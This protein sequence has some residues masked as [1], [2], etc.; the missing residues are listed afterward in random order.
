MINR[1]LAGTCAL[2]L[3]GC[4]GKSGSYTPPKSDSSTEPKLS[5]ELTVENVFPLKVGNQWVYTVEESARNTKGQTASGK[6]E[7][8]WKVL[9]V[10]KDG[11]TTRATIEVTGKNRS[12]ER[13]VWELNSKG[14]FQVGIGPS[15]KYMF[16]PPMPALLFP[17]SANRKF[18]WK[19]TSMA[20]GGKLVKMVVEGTIGAPRSADTAKEP[21]AAIPVETKMKSEDGTTTSVST[22]FFA[23]KV[24][25]VR[26][27]SEITAKNG[28]IARRVVLKSFREVQ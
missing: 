7:F 15:G 18:T 14:L 20:D 8:T 5:T 27:V 28:S 1:L 10:K 11:D 17:V 22:S 6:G 21:I 9:S 26:Y 3:I 13:Q 25:M 23:P 24:G 16:N 19:G 2:A 12:I 4:G